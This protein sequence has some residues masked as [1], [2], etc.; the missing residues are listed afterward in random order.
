MLASQLRIGFSKG[1]SQLGFQTKIYCSFPINP[2]RAHANP[3]HLSWFENP[4]NKEIIKLIIYSKT[5]MC[6][7]V[8][9]RVAHLAIIVI[10]VPF[11]TR[12]LLEML[13]D[14]VWSPEG[15]RGLSCQVYC[16][17]LLLI[18]GTIRLAL[19]GATDCSS[20]SHRLKKSTI[21][22]IL[23]WNKGI[24]RMLS[25]WVVATHSPPSLTLLSHS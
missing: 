24:V 7:N 25:G 21:L 17:G 13:A 2:M 3:Y 15:G 5:V 6:S 22:I 1:L 10:L 11:I 4:G 23:Q 16:E 14:Q 20:T 12:N 8:K 18:W 9:Y 19:V